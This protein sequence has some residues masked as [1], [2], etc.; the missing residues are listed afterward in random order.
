MAEAKDN[1]AWN[2]TCALMAK[3]HNAFSEK[4]SETIDPMLFYPWALDRQE[5]NAPPPTEEER[6]MLREA[7]PGKK[8]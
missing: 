2:R 1:A 7:F 6:A 8:G 3:W 4:D 5:K